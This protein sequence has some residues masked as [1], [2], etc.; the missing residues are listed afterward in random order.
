MASPPGRRPLPTALKLL[1]GNP[2]KRRLN[3]AEPQAPT[4]RPS[5]PAHLGPIARKEWFRIIRELETLGIVTPLDRA[6]LAAYC[7]SWEQWIEATEQIRKFGM[8]IKMGATLI[9]SPYVTIADKAKTQM[10]NFLTEF[11][12]TPSSRSRIAAPKAN[13]DEDPNFTGG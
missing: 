5:C 11:G 12:M 9:Q 8:V 3:A 10:R 1:R 6:A 4:T 2:G 13:A 7:D